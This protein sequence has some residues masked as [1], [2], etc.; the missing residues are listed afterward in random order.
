[1]S[2]LYVIICGKAETTRRFSYIAEYFHN[3]VEYQTIFE[4]DILMA[5]KSVFPYPA[6]DGISEISKIYSS[7]V[8]PKSLSA[9]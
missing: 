9:Y 6:R 5:Q 8:F 2:R 1:M 7:Y 4:L 3:F